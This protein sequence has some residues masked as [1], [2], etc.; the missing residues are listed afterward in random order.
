MRTENVFNFNSISKRKSVAPEIGLATDFSKWDEFCIWLGVKQMANSTTTTPLEWNSKVLGL[1]GALLAAGITI[2]TLIWYA[3]GLA[4]D[5]RYMQKD[6]LNQSQRIERIEEYQR[7][8]DLRKEASRG[9][10]MGVAESQA[11]QNKKNNGNGK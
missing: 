6:M 9:F 2:G 7:Q 3:S 1:A 8:A 5:L 11:A 10:E 4:A